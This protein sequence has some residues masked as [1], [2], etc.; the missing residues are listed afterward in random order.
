MDLEQKLTILTEAARYDAS[1]ATSGSTRQAPA[2]CGLGGTYRAGICHSW[3]EDGRCVSLLKVLMSNAC[4]FNCAYCANRCTSN[5]A[6]ATFTPREVAELTV[7]FFR[8]NY[9]EGLF[10]SS[11]IVRNADYTMEMIAETIRLLRTEYRFY[12]Y[13]HA[14]VVPGADPLLIQRVGLMADRVSVNIELPSA[15]SLKLLAPQKSKEKILTPMGQIQRLKTQNLAERKQFRAAPKFAPA[16]QSTQMIIGATDDSDSKI[17][18]LT[19]GLYRNYDLKRVYFSAYVPVGSHPSLPPASVRTPLR[20]EH[21][22][23]QADWLLRKYQFNVLELIEDGENLDEAVDP[24]CSWALRHPD[25]FPVEVNTADEQT[26]LRVPG[27]GQVSARRILAARRCH[28]IAIEDLPK[29]GVVVRRARF[30]VTCRGKMCFRHAFAPEIL[31]EILAD[32]REDPA[33]MSLAEAMQPQLPAP[34]V[35]RAG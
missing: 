22:L 35:E 2:G 21:R 18:R 3:S 25:F 12:G 7:A 5:V 23:Y 19:E 20:R 14:K 30:F 27:I 17:L 16:G 29:L 24:K 15:D 6:R 9:I 13:I 26:L 1:C 33:Q 34:K 31:R 11:G 8:R 28:S 32:E 4:M 10:L